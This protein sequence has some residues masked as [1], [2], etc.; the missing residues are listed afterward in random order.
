MFQTSERCDAVA[1]EMPLQ[2]A[3]DA[4][5]LYLVPGP[6]HTNKAAHNEWWLC[7]AMLNSALYQA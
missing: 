6:V 4:M 5:F 2:G 1:R 3:G 7:R